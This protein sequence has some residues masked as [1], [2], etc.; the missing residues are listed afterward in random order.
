MIT[1]NDVQRIQSAFPAELLDLPQWVGYFLRP[2]D[3][4]GKTDKV[5]VNPVNGKLAQ[6]NDSHTWGTFQEAVEWALGQ[7]LDGIGFVL[8]AGDP[9]VGIDFDHCLDT[10]NWLT[11][12]PHVKA[13]ESYTEISPS[14]TGLHVWVKA[15]LPQGGRRRGSVEMYAA[16]RFLT[17]T[18]NR[19]PGFP[20]TVE[21]RQEQ[22]TALY[23]KLT[24][25]PEAPPLRAQ[26]SIPG[27]GEESTA[28]SDDAII[29]QASN[30]LN[31]EK[32]TRLWQGD[33]TGYTSPSEADLALCNLL[34]F[35]TGKNATQMGR[36]FQRSG[37]YRAKWDEPHFADGHTY[38]QET[39]S[40]AIH[41]VTQVYSANGRGKVGP[42]RTTKFNLTDLGNA[43][44]LIDQHGS[45][46]HYCE[47]WEKWLTWDSTCWNIGN[48][49][50]IEQ[51]AAL[52]VRSIYAEAAQI[53]DPDDR[54]AVVKHAFR[55]EAAG[56]IQ[57]MIDLARGLEGVPVKSSEMDAN[58]WLLN[59]NN[60][61]LDLHS[62]DLH[63]H[64]RENR[65]T[66]LAP[67]AHDPNALC[68]T[69]DAFLYRIMAG[70]MRLIGFLRRA[71]GYA[72]TGEVSEQCFF[73]LYGTGQNGKSTFLETIG[74]VLNDYRVHTPTETILTKRGDSI[75]NDIA[76]L[77]GARLVTAIETDEGKRLAESLVK[78][79]TGGDTVVAR[80][81]RAEWFEFKPEFKLF[82]ATN[83]KPVIRGTDKA[84]WRRIRLIPFTV[85][86]PDAEQDKAL[87]DKLKAELPGILNWCVQGC[88]DWQSEGLGAPEEVKAATAEYRREMDV[89]AVFL[90]E[91]CISPPRGGDIQDSPT[92]LK[93]RASELYNAYV[94]WCEENN[95]YKMSGTT[96]GRRLTE[97]GF[98]K[99]RQDYG[100]EYQG[101]GVLSNQ[102]VPGDSQ[103]ELP[104]Q[105]PLPF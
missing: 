36:L 57:S 86:I 43:E 69:W 102:N 20:A 8:T 95:E 13:L 84:I 51:R 10:G 56:R 74:A 85:T 50:E 94:K 45:D 88:L 92:P 105:A 15:T 39:I 33:A 49:A 58:S 11:Y 68:P 82:L 16:G 4:P 48:R 35:W 3:K 40:K 32:F 64:A 19:F 100:W 30:A 87:P 76:R 71:V 61:T 96:F 60:G 24:P 93:T 22:V 70:N 89:L 99:K 6:V 34:A 97:R 17:V 66:K 103:P 28:L 80:F 98:E 9:Y 29:A 1:N 52:T 31:G 90:T 53:D 65:I 77:R 46:L 37:L 78:Q 21:E 42:Q 2:K 91:C 83:H 73:I 59:V 14:G 72:L 44:R 18:G 25:P 101:I 38:G 12:E 26:H 81:M 47:E 5:P 67:I 27:G 75:P 23:E 63:E 54:K 7:G 41:D 79:M 55:S 104:R 62:G